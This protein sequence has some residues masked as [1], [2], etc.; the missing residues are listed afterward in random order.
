[1]WTFDNLPSNGL[2]EKYGFEPSTQWLDHVRLS[3]VRFSDGGSGSFISS[4]GLILTNHH[5][6]LDQLQKSS[7]AEHDYVRDSFYARTRGEEIK[8]PD[9]YIDVLVSMENIT[10]EINKRTAAAANDQEKAK[11]RR[12]AIGEIEKESKST[13]GLEAEIVTLYGG[14]EYWLYRYKRYTDVRIV[15]APEQQSAFFGGDPDN[16]TYPRYDLDLAMFRAYENDQP[17]HSENYLKWNSAGAK[18]EELVFV[19]GHPGSTQRNATFSTYQFLIHTFYPSAL[20]KLQLL[21]DADQTYAKGGAEQEREAHSE[22]FG[23]QNSIKAITGIVKAGSDADLI[24]KKQNRER[25]FKSKVDGNPEWKKVFG[26]AWASVEEANQQYA[27]R[28]KFRIA[29]NLDSDLDQIAQKIVEYV[30]EVKKP[31]G[32]RLPGFQDAQLQTLK[33]QLLSPAPVY[34]EFEKARLAAS[35]KFAADKLG[36][37]APF[38]KTALDGRTPAQVASEVI[39]GTKLADPAFRKQLIDGGS[40][41]VDASTDP[42]IV[43]ERKLDP[44]RREEIT[45]YR[46]HVEAITQRAGEQLG[47]ARFAVYGKALYPD[48]TFTLRLSYGQMKGYPMN[49]TIAPPITTVYGLYDR[50]ESFSK[51][52]PFNLPER[53]EA[54]KSKLNL[55]TPFDFVSSN[56][57]IGGNSGSPVVNREGELVGLIFDG[58]IESLAGD[59]IYDGRTNRAV[60][61]HTAVMTEALRKLYDVAPLLKEIGL[62][63]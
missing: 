36:A 23:L 7:S 27:P 14:G 60:S 48:G 29:Y 8:S 1:M 15:F 4:N 16:F 50:A 62:S 54:G 39:T 21:V 26:N 38:V 46:N 3:C 59:L 24:A 33:Y 43:F 35:L 2:R 52:P 25:E 17:V 11:V 28:V 37:E 53:F 9:L 30:S 55:A 12:G 41:A 10:A 31:A 58:N 49:G 19:S 47:Q 32:E 56:D 6:A 45:W 44:I 40:S 20:E 51:K 57:I 22:I 61:V 13:T 42:L 18:D 63:E 34:P 5:V